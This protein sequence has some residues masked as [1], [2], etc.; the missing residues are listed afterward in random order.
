MHLLT[1]SALLEALGWTLFNSLWQMGLLWLTYQLLIRVFGQVSSRFR[2]GLALVLLAFG[3]LGSIVTFAATYFFDDGGFTFS[4]N[5]GFSTEYWVAVVLPYC[6]SL[7]LLVL[8]G[9]FIRY[10]HQYI[11]SR[12]LTRKGLAKLPAEFRVFAAA[13]SRRMG[14]RPEVRVSLSTL[15]DVPLTLGALKPI[16]LLPVAMISH[17]TPQ[18]VEAILLHEL[19]HIRRKDYL[20]NLG[21][22]VVGLLFFFNPFTR[23]LIRELQREREH[24]C[25]DEVL[26]FNYDPHAYVSALLSLARQHR[27]GRLALAATGGSD[28]LLLQRARKMLQ[29]KRTDRRPGARPFILIFLTAAITVFSLARPARTGAGH[30]VAMAKQPAAMAQQ[31][32]AVAIVASPKA[33]AGMAIRPQ[34]AAVLV[35]I[36]MGFSPIVNNGVPT[37]P[38]HGRSGSRLDAQPAPAGK[39]AHSAGQAGEAGQHD[40][41]PLSENG[42]IGSVAGT[43]D[44]SATTTLILAQPATLTLPDQV[45]PG[46]RDYSL[47]GS[48]DEGQEAAGDLQSQDGL[49]F[50]PNSS[51]S[52]QNIDTLRPEEKL[53]WIEA[54]TEREIRTQ[55]G[56]LQRELTAQLEM[57]R[58]QENQ[59][60]TLSA[61]EQQQLKKWLNQQLLIQRD[62]LRKLDELHLQLKKAAHRLTTV[63]I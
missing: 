62:Y 55:V 11:H 18:Q 48:P 2:H 57:L 34:D 1:Q 10:S 25:D 47:G 26:Q 7:Y 5:L 6:S 42:L 17:L 23:M 32:A 39:R 49:V 22:T 30:F 61:S 27:Q 13:T 41:Q 56:R 54:S 16:I 46:K 28:Q 36:E 19:A 44:R 9:L 43:G 33:A 58:R 8:G 4:G 35:S 3:A 63:Y 53:T 52:F 37:Q 50:V 29:Q 20:L 38:Q 15:V 59:I 45:P 14:I 12:Q 60:H 40:V 24:C 21:V 51:F 31:P